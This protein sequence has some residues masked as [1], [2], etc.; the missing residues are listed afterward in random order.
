MNTADALFLTN[1]EYGYLFGPTKGDKVWGSP[2][3]ISC[4]DNKAGMFP[5]L[6]K[7]NDQELGLFSLVERNSQQSV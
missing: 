6:K 4:L 3:E 1:R 7:N 2:F 5:K